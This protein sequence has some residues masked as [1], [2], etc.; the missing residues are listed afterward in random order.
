VLG[1]ADRH[2]VC[3]GD[4]KL[5]D[6]FPTALGQTL[7]DGDIVAVES[8]ERGG[9]DFGV[10]AVWIETVGEGAESWVRVENFLFDEFL[11][12]VERRLIM[13]MKQ[14]VRGVEVVVEIRR[15]R[16]PWVRVDVPTQ[17]QVLD[18]L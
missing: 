8:G 13:L 1:L 18:F 11:F 4:C 2:A 5:A 6:W 17:E 15:E 7:V 14:V 10:A 12:F 16:W 9:E 3:D